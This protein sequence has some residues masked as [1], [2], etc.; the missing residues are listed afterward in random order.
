MAGISGINISFEIKKPPLGVMPKE[1]WIEKRKLDLSRAIN[2][3]VAARIPFKHEWID[4][5]KDLV[6]RYP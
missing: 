4:E 2:E 5:L 3:Y 6:T 1:I